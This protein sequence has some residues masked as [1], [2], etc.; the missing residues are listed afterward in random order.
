MS[1][2]AEEPTSA[3]ADA[4]GI[5]LDGYRIKPV[6]SEEPA[7]KTW[8]E[9]WSRVMQH[10]RSLSVRPFSLLD[11]AF[12]AT[13]NLLR[14]AGGMP[15]AL[16]ERIEGAHR[17]ADQVEQKQQDE[18]SEGSSPRPLAAR[19]RQELQ[20]LVFGEEPRALSMARKHGERA[21]REVGFGEDLGDD[22]RAQGR[23]TRGLQHE[24]T[25]RRDRRSDL[26]S[27]QVEREVEG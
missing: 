14:G 13:E 23:L 27:R 9:V 2:V 10:L 19:A 8:S 25:A 26:V 5:Q 16:S 3:D 1:D 7:P 24:R 20:T 12:R 18:L 15:G 17:R 22:Q 4:G 6:D 11:T 21:F